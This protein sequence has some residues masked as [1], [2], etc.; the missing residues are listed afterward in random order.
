ML[1]RNWSVLYTIEATL[2]MLFFIQAL[3]FIVGA[4]YAH[5]GSASL[6]PAL[7]PNLIDPNL[8]GLVEPSTVSSELALIG[9]MLLLPLVALFMGRI[10][11]LLFP[12]A[13]IAAIGRYMMVANG[14]MTPDVTGAAVT[15]GGGLLYLS[16]VIRH[17]AQVLP[18][19]FILAIAIDQLFRAQG[20]TLD[21][22]W[23]YAY[24]NAQMLLSGLVIILSIG[25][26]F[27]QEKQ[28]KNTEQI[29][30]DRGLMPFWGGVALGAMLFLQF[31][32]LALPNA[33]ARR[34]DTDYTLFVPAIMFATLLPLLPVVRGRARWFIGLFD[35]NLRGWVWMLIAML[36]I[37]FGLRFS[38]I[39]AGIAL[40]L[41]QFVVSM[42]WWWFIR[43]QAKKERNWGELWL[44]LG[45]V[46]FLFLVVFDIFTYEYAFVRDFSPEL[47][48]LNPIIPPLLRGLRG[49]GLMVIL[50][51]VF[52]LM[53][54]MVRTRKRIAWRDGTTLELI[55][56]L[57]LL[58]TF[59]GLVAYESQPPVV[60][61]VNNPESIR[62]GTYNIHAGYNELFHYDLE[63]IARTIQFSG[64]DVVLLQEV[65]TG[66]M[67]SYGVDQALWLARRLKMDV[68]FF[69]TNE[70]LQGL[71]VL[72]KIEIVFDDGVLL[73]SI[74]TQTGL[75]RVQVRPDAGVITIY[76]TWL[77]PLLDTGN[78]SQTIQ[79]LEAAQNTQLSE[80]F[81]IIAAH[82]PNGRLGRIIIGGTFNNIPDSDVMQRMVANGFV[83]HFANEP[84]DTVATFV[85][86]GTRARLD[87]LWTTRSVNFQVVVATVIDDITRQTLP[88]QASD[89]R[90]AL[91]QVALR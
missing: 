5:V 53:M 7:N 20:D 21:P 57:V 10:H 50:L 33:V 38:G 80:I 55:A 37:V 41:A 35:A 13:T 24:L 63:L 65:E 1:K 52:L 9:Y 17:R 58:L 81:T 40:T 29:L 14:Q 88:S 79:D 89:H 72:S 2:V 25:L 67:T 83:D 32:L 54:P 39:L 11:W 76:N 62:I 61:G 71:A 27:A 85:R 70:G 90:M 4:I 84:P 60:Q 56:S 82:H 44:V 30:M 86:T 28:I 87:Y 91:I 16:L 47:D 19:M 66:R 45:M 23:D 64:A 46:V 42:T 22:S 74:G 75:Q 8:P 15:L 18:G 48:F 73:N 36:L 68:R 49:L 26:V 78:A 69:P 12:A 59:S 51:A 43:P 3:R 34:G 6:Y 77:E 31:S